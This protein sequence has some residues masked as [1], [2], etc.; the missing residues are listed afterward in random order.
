MQPSLYG[1]A[2]WYIL[3]TFGA[4]SSSPVSV[5]PGILVSRAGCSDAVHLKYTSLLHPP[6]PASA[7][8][9]AWHKSALGFKWVSDIPINSY[10][11][12]IYQEP[13]IYSAYGE[14]WLL[15]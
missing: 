15:Q 6:P 10:F 11:S 8:L 13:S 12:C 7:S 5:L 4:T 9:R 14:T 1:Q 3:S 2:V